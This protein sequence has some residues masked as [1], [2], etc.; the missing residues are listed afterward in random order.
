[1]M[2]DEIRD[3]LVALRKIVEEARNAAQA[4]KEEASDKGHALIIMLL[5]FILFSI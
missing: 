4:A 5:S 2:N 1:M 3:E